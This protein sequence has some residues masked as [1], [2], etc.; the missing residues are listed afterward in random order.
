MYFNLSALQW[1]YYDAF[2]ITPG[3]LNE[4]MGGHQPE[5]KTSRNNQGNLIRWWKINWRKTKLGFALMR[6]FRAADKKISE[7]TSYT[8]ALIKKGC[9]NLKDAEILALFDEIGRVSRDSTVL[10]LLNMSAGGYLTLL[11]Q[12]LEKSFPGRG[13][14]MANA[15]MVGKRRIPTAE[16]GYRL[17]EMAE[18]VRNDPEAQRYFSSQD[19][20]PLAWESR[21]P[22]S[23]IFKQ[24]FRAFLEE[25]GHRLVNEG[26]LSN[27]RWREDPSYLLNVIKSMINT[28][29]SAGM[30]ERQ[31][32]M[33]EKAWKDIVAEVPFYRRSVIKKLITLTVRGVELREMARSTIVRIGE[34]MRMLAQEVG[35][36]F[37]ERGILEQ[38]DDVYH[39]S[40]IELSAVL[41]GQWDGKELKILVSERKEKSKEMEMLS[42]PDIVIDDIPQHVVSTY[43]LDGKVLEGI[44]VS[45]GK[46][47]GPARLVHNIDEGIKLNHGEVLVAPATDPGWTPLFLHAS[48]VVTETGGFLSHSSIV[49]R[50][51]GIPAVVNIPGVMK[52]LK[53]G[54]KIIVDGDEGKVY[55]QQCKE[56][57]A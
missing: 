48:A 15:L 18:M 29:D 36:R 13:K 5:I 3:E 1:E 34:P 28:A 54:Q 47:E 22:N 53:D 11:V 45:A 6:A 23:S 51:Y 20:T 40:W 32:E 55:L 9:L 46:A 35:Q 27:P 21:L 24:K 7:I 12:T 8:N 42:P 52:V 19:Y 31:R 26:D 43:K 30:K 14:A 56:L 50:E 2:G 49:A 37:K 57:E 39:C 33:A 44:G 41:T 17:A 25:F 38:Q 10:H 4:V 16:H